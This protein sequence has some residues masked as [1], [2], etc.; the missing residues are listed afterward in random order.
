MTTARKQ[1]VS[2][3]AT[4]YY[5]CVSRCV[6]RSFL[7][8]KD[9]LT[10]RSYEH[11]REWIRQKI[12]ALSQV[13]CIDVCAY[14]IMSNHY[15][16]VLHINREKAL[17]LSHLEVVQR[18]REHHK[19]PML[20]SRWLSSELTSE[21]EIDACL[22]IIESWRA[23]LWNLSWF[24]KEL[25]YD[26]AC[27]ANQEDDCSGHFWESR[28]KSQA[29]LDEQ[30][31]VAAMAYVDL[32]PLR[33]GTADT[34]ESS[35]YTSFQARL[36]ALNRYQ[37]TA[38]C[39]HPFIGSRRSEKREGIPFLLIEYLE[40]V[41]WTA[42]QFCQNKACMK[43]SEPALLQ[44]LNLPQSQWLD[45]CKQLEQHRSTAIGCACDIGLIK[46]CLHKKR[47]HLL[48]LNG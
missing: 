15:H 42:R 29:L 32:N 48:R 44:R 11:R 38:P 46:S 47:I 41:D 1:L 17:A 27:Q 2:V 8:G 3:E 23:R 16:L 40:L 30:A 9:P 24:M 33:A 34:P 39:L 5:H 10:K 37:D 21:G 19:L 13:Y 35:E 6:R 22:S 45:V 7:C 18:W 20:V 12:Y 4:P 14:A 43:V 31:L 26:I 25:N 28:F 36:V